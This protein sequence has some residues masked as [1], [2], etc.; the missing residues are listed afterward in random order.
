MKPGSMYPTL[1][2][3]FSSKKPGFLPYMVAKVVYDVIDFVPSFEE[4]NNRVETDEAS[5]SGD[6]NFLIHQ[7]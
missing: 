4:P 1:W 5:C 2:I 6:E 7:P 3:M